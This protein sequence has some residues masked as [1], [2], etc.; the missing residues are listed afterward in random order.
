MKKIL[1]KLPDENTDDAMKLMPHSRHYHRYFEGYRESLIIDEN[2]RK[3]IKRQ[4]I[5]RY[6]ER[7]CSD[8]Q[9]IFVKLLYFALALGAVVLFSWSGL[10]SLPCGRVFAVEL[11]TA[12]SVFSLFAEIIVTLTCLTKK[13]KMDVHDYK[14]AFAK[15]KTISLLASLCM[16][17]N[18]ISIMACTVM[19]GSGERIPSY[20]AAAAALSAAALLMV[21]HILEARATY[22]VTQAKHNITLND[23]IIEA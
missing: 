6:Y 8:R 3:R 5:G 22:I 10:Q 16:A 14:S 2:G 17:V 11:S 18:G 20:L 15:V 1:N 21:Q 19:I 4:Y 23:N 7:K 13:R 9:W 12:A